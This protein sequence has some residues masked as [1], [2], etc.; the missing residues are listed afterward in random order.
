M[1]KRIIPAVLAALLA[2]S[3]LAG[4][5]SKDDAE[6]GGA[7]AA[8][9][10][11]LVAV[12]YENADG[13]IVQS[14]EYAYADGV[15]VSETTR[16]DESNWNTYR[17]TFDGQGRLTQKK[18]ENGTLQD[19]GNG[20]RDEDM[21]YVYDAAGHVATHAYSGP[22]DTWRDEAFTYDGDLI[23]GMERRWGSTTEGWTFTGKQD[24]DGGVTYTAHCDTN[25]AED[26]TYVYDAEGRMTQDYDD[27]WGTPLY[28]AYIDDPILTICQTKG[29]MNDESYST[30]SAALTDSAG[31][32]IDVVYLGNTEGLQLER[33]P[34]GYLVGAVPGPG[35][36]WYT[37][38]RLVYE[39][40][41]GAQTP[42]AETTEAPAEPAGTTTQTEQKASD[43]TLSAAET[44]ALLSD[45]PETFVFSS[46]AGGWGTELHINADGTFVGNYHDSDMGVTGED[47]PNGTVSIC[48]FTGAFTDF[49]RVSDTV[50]TMRLKEL[51]TARTPGEEYIENGVR[52]ICSDPYGM[53]DAD[54]FYLYLPGTP[55][56]VLPEQ[57]ISW[58]WLE[59]SA[60]SLPADFY[61]LYNQGGEQG[62]SG[63]KH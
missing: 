1:R 52:Y 40:L 16:Q 32:L 2:L 57:F 33:D 38:I 3:L 48:D 18:W 43:G 9:D 10:R 17:F 42:A 25:A 41:E 45:L 54:L 4:C 15:L 46:G 58:V 21:I 47:Y 28:Y 11:R 59:D 20:R 34:D 27:Y 44:Q 8:P 29:T 5:G 55:R 35:D 31:N 51:H 49:R 13:Q 7:A 39:P 36:T 23:T 50:Y 19:T 22:T 63:H 14:T 37:H 56:S 26:V 61:G 53:D 6:S 60:Q 62:Y 24:D 30:M 12:Y